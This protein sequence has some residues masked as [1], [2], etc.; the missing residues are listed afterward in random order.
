MLQHEGPVSPTILL[1]QTRIRTKRWQRRQTMVVRKLVC[2][3]ALHAYLSGCAREANVL[4]NR[5]FRDGRSCFLFRYP[6][7][8]TFISARQRRAVPGGLPHRVQGSMR[9]RRVR[10]LRLGIPS[11]SFH[12]ASLSGVLMHFIPPPFL[13]TQRNGLSQHPFVAT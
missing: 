8:S 6:S 13:A 2:C 11:L 4:G 10:P 7:P 5:M 12:S 9:D 1:L 3:L